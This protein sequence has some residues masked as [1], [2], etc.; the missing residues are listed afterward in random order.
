MF[1]RLDDAIVRR[2]LDADR[3]ASGFP[4]IA[5]GAELDDALRDHR[6]DIVSVLID[7]ISGL[8]LRGH[9]TLAT[10]LAEKYAEKGGVY[11]G[12][13]LLGDI[14]DAYEL[15]VASDREEQTR[16][17]IDGAKLFNE[18]AR[19]QDALRSEIGEFDLG[20]WIK[21]LVGDIGWWGV[22]TRPSC[23]VARA[24]G[25]E[26]PTLHEEA[27]EILPVVR[28]L[29]LALCNEHSR[30]EDAWGLT[31]AMKDAF[32]GFSPRYAV[33]LDEDIDA[34]DRL[35]ERKRAAERMRA[36]KEVARRERA[37]KERAER[38]T[39]E[40]EARRR[41]KE[42]IER[43]EREKAERE[44]R[45]AEKRQREKEEAEQREREKAAKRDVVRRQ[46]KEDESRRAYEARVDELRREKE[47]LD[48]LL[49]EAGIV[50]PEPKREKAER[51]AKE[52]AERAAKERAER[53]ARKA[54]DEGP[55]E[56]SVSSLERLKRMVAESRAKRDDARGQRAR[57][58][59]TELR[60]MAGA[61]EAE[62]TELERQLITLDSYTKSCETEDGTMKEGIDVKAY[63]DA[64]KSYNEIYDRYDELLDRYNGL[65]KEHNE[66]TGE[67][68]TGQ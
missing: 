4:T 35:I 56:T 68:A 45:E 25:L 47:Q 46:R 13:V 15:H 44:A 16:K 66:L 18:A 55:S 30:E 1:E 9:T 20:G 53:E 62:I 58:R 42:E 41:E 27:E 37:A 63:R 60:D 33:M 34:L 28:S 61:L 6:K 32:A 8:D 49:I 10:R 19:I 14:V 48:R 26:H 40:A 65:V 21:L 59:A 22:L 51:E 11:E 39:R 31:I 29:A 50:A 54:K 57:Q 67:R 36:E 5:P 38:A 24:R 43:R 7:K 12:H 2:E 64:I 3:E 17:I 23:L 52:K